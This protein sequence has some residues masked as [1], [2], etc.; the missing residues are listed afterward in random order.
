MV[1]MRMASNVLETYSRV[2]DTE[3]DERLLEEGEELGLMMKRRGLELR[4]WRA[5]VPV[6]CS[7]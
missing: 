3:G 5:D 2:L 7:R 1:V 4:N 6:D